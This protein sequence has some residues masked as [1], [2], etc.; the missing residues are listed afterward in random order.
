MD[1]HGEERYAR[2]HGFGAARDCLAFHI[3]FAHDQLSKGAVGGIWSLVWAPFS[4]PYICTHRLSVMTH[5]SSLK[6]T[7]DTHT[8]VGVVCS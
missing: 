3:R 1:R 8:L 5:R 4:L 2:A 6:F 7:G